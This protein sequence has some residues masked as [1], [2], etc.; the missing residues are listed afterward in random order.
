MKSHEM[1]HPG[2]V[3]RSARMLGFAL[4]VLSVHAHAQ[5]AWRPERPVEIVVGSSPGG[6]TDLTARV[7][8]KI[9]QE[10]RVV[11]SAV[12]VNKPGGGQT[13]SWVYMNQH[14][15]DGHYVSIVNE[16]LLTNRIMGVS[17]LGHEDFTPLAVLFHEHVVFMT[18][19]DSPLKSGR[20]LVDRLQKDPAG[21]SF[22]F[23]SSRG[24]NTH[25]AIGLLAKAAGL[26]TR[27]AK[28]VVFKSGGEAITAL[29]GSHVDVGSSTVAPA[30]QHLK[31]GRL[32]ALA[33]ASKARLGGELSTI[34]TW[35]EQGVDVLY[36]SWRV[37]FGPKGMT[38]EQIAFWEKALRE[39]TQTPEWKA[40]LARSYREDAFSGSGEARKFLDG[41]SRRLKPLLT[42]L[43]LAKTDS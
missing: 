23:G 31:A 18:A 28:V 14:A 25:I 13:V 17:P 41:E 11:D 32:Q 30:V 27:K 24:N 6:G 40:D 29:L 16:P 33:V 12:V 43:S 39:A 7:L 38:R 36:A 20:S 1:V 34:P 10:R 42:E 2:F 37:V 22:G 9:L 35:R 21:L 3:K 8:Q 26:D 19:A 4:A 5:S 15:G